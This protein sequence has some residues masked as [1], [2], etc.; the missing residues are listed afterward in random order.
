MRGIVLL[1]D[2]F[3]PMHVDR[4]E[5]VAA[6]FA[7]EARV[8]GCEL[9]ARSAEYEWARA[10]TAQARIETLFSGAARPGRLA[11]LWRLI[12]FRRRIGRA[13]W[14]ICHYERPEILAFAALLRL[15][16]ARVHTMG[17]SKFDDLPRRAGREWLKSFFL[18]P[19]RGAIGSGTR[20]ADYLRFLGL[21]SDRIAGEYNT[22]SITRL[23]EMAGVPAAPGGSDHAERH[24]ICVARFVPKKNLPTLLDAYARYAAGVP[25]P[26]RLHLCGSGRMEDQLRAKVAELG[27]AELVVFEGFLQTDGVARLL[28]RSLALLLPSVEEQFGNV[29]IEAQALGVPVILADNCGARDKLVRAAVNGFVVEADNPEGMAWFMRVL[30]QDRELWRGMAERAAASAALGDTSRFAEAVR[31]LRE[32]HA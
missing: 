3:G 9:F 22:V 21:R 16:G 30:D 20:S 13:D 2:N 25:A 23:R 28:G 32:S 1:W 19:Y 14:F 11:R 15:T 18:L 29:V 5:A 31:A 7:G 12:G 6:E 27:L 8:V 4:L 10:G 26:R 24:F 17:C